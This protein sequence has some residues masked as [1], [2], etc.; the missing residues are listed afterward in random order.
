MTKFSPDSKRMVEAARKRAHLLSVAKTTFEAHGYEGT[1][2]RGVAAECGFSTGAIFGHF[3][4]KE[5]L[6][7]EC[8][9]TDHQQR[10]VAEAI[11]LAMGADWRTTAR[12]E[13]MLAAQASG[14]LSDRR[15]A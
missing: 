13:W 7:I 2:L 12:D 5:A 8:F 10:R 11:C 6:F 15:A 14:C 9:P 4:S 3:A 1:D